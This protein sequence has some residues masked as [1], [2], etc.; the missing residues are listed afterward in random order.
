VCEPIAR[1]PR[2]GVVPHPAAERTPRTR[3]ARATRH[4][5]IV[6]EQAYES[7]QLGPSSTGFGAPHVM[8]GYKGRNNLAH[9][10]IDEPTSFG[11]KPNRSPRHSDVTSGHR[12]SGVRRVHQVDD[13]LQIF[14]RTKLDN[15]LAFTFAQADR[16][17]SVKGTR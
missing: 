6:T 11:N 9:S 10:T 7:A 4:L 16:D 17:A 12:Q 15:N 5:L 8:M 13:A 1:L 2:D 3:P 14:Y